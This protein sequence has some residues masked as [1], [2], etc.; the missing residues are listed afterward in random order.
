[1]VDRLN[2]AAPG[3]DA[4]NSQRLFLSTLDAVPSPFTMLAMS[5]EKNKFSSHCV[6]SKNPFQSK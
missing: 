5:R 3:L 1:M 4:S 2:L 6:M